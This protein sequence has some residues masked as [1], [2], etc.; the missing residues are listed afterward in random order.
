MRNV[1]SPRRAFM[2]WACAC[3]SIMALPH[4]AL[5]EEP[6]LELVAESDTM[7]WNGVAVDAKRIFVAGPRWTGSRGPALGLVEG[8]AVVPYPDAA[9][10]AWRPGGDAAAAFVNVNAVHLGPDGDLWVVDTGSPDFGGDPLPGGAKLVRIDL[11]TNRV[12]RIYLF[13]SRIALPG[14]YV[15]DVRL[16]G[17]HAY[18]TDAGRPGLIVLDLETG[19]ARRVLDGH[20]S[21]T[22]PSDRDIELSGRVIRAPNG[23]PLR[24]HA[25]P[26][27]ISP[28]GR[29]L[30][31]GPLAGPWSRIETR[32]LGDAAL[33]ADALT[34]KVEPWADLPPV[35]G[36]A[37]AADGTLYFTDLAL[38][39]VR[40]RAPD[41]TVRT[42]LADPK[43]HWVDA[44]FLDRRGNLWL[45][46]P[47]MDRSDLFVGADG[48]RQWPVQ[49]YRI[50]VSP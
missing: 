17:R 16:N 11:R 47:Q 24:V 41:G 22:A 8:G 43:L 4:P 19:A 1:F 50:K 44:P 36:T 49:L 2:G 42:L 29:W 3:A 46:V 13:G 40:A 20:V 27:E 10:N 33:A 38:N 12:V 6:R 7:I 23:S 15:D 35:G 37:L 45:P 26:L 28:D 39:A 30:Y 48:P 21:V 18:L 9:W 31:F 14:S 34:Q 32:A 25:D 5:T